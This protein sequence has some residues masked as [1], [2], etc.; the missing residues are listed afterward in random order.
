MAVPAGVGRIDRNSRDDH[1]SAR[2]GGPL[3]QGRLW[4]SLL[5]FSACETFHERKCF[6]KYATYVKKHPSKTV[7]RGIKSYQIPVKTDP[8]GIKTSTKTPYPS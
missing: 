4:S 8:K 6:C 1:N 5:L 7:K 2:I 3:R